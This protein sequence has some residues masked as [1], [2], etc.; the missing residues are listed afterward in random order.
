MTVAGPRRVA[1]RVF[2][3]TLRDAADLLL[4]GFIHPA[5]SPKGFIFPKT[6]KLYGYRIEGNSVRLVDEPEP[7]P[8]QVLL[9]VRPCDAAAFPILDHIFNWDCPD[10]FYNRRR[11]TT[12]I[13]ALACTAHDEHCFCTSVGLAPASER[14]ADAMLIPDGAGG[15]ELRTI[16][17]KGKALFSGM[18][19]SPPAEAP[20]AQA[21]VASADGPE[22]R[23]DAAAAG[24]FAK[25]N[26][27]HALWAEQALAC[28]GCGACA[29]NCPTCHCFDIVDEHKARVR[30]WDSCQFGLFTLHASGHN[31]RPDQGARQ[32]QR[33]L[34]KFSI[35][36]EKFGD[37]LCTGCGTCS[38][39]C[40]AGLGVLPVLTAIDHGQHL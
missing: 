39:N 20:E 19:S 27:T 34:H 14:G 40:P 37:I 21:K 22:R 24:S 35:Y 9:G 28:L 18:E 30:N 7:A 8:K 33:I 2:Y 36:P 38:R 31:P 25:A 15:F 17:E 3:S 11:E 5:N 26:F 29:H 23:F 4:D 16:T 13:V 10:E 12:T 32:R 1:G 6:E